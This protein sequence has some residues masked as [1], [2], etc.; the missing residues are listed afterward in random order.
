MEKNE[1]VVQTSHLE[2]IVP[3]NQH[4]VTFNNV[5]VFT[6]EPESNNQLTTNQ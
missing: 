6:K 4:T 1:L 2:V 3:G 5:P